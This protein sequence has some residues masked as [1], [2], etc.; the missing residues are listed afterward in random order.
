M[1]TSVSL[2]DLMLFHEVVSAGSMS[3]ASVRLGL[4]KSTISRSLARLE[5]QMQT[6]LIKRSTRKLMLTDIGEDVY[7]RCKSIAAELAILE[8]ATE[9]SRS[10]LQGTLRV[11]L[12]NEFGSAWLGRAISEF[13]MNY[14]ELCLDI[15]VNS[16][17][18]D[19]IAESYDVAIHLGRLRS[20][21]L[22]YRRLAS[23][24]RSIYASPTY[25][26]ANAAINHPE[27]LRGAEFI[28][29]EVQRREGNLVLR[30]KSA[31][32]TVK[33]HGRIAVNSLRIARELVVG[34]AGIGILPD[35]MSEKYVE[36]GTLV[37]V[38]EQWRVPPVLASATVLAREGIPRK[39]RVFLDFIAERL[40]APDPAVKAIL[41]QVDPENI[42]LQ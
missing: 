15:D 33:L 1:K 25:L 37:R 24:S 41:M 32:R 42:D 23:L 22:A 17:A 39:T 26:S 20:S 40:A 3:R 31:R 6:L 5:T 4:A 19:L 36:S 16:H 14:P 7:E 9:E 13:A 8:N 2:D 18:V 21:Q 30:S 27:D 35:A 28:V 11:S 10:V 34:G 12:P 38:L 29:T